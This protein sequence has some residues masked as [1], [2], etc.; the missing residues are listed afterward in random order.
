MADSKLN[1]IL[2][3]SEEAIEPFKDCQ[4]DDLLHPLSHFESIPIHIHSG[5][6]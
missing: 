4:I 3:S 1:K 2:F 6:P 5:R